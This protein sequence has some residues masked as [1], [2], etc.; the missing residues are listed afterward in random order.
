MS[1][2]HFLCCIYFKTAAYKLLG[3]FINAR[4][5]KNWHFLK[6]FVNFFRAIAKTIFDKLSIGSLKEVKTKI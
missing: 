5:V 4:A 3:R 2:L 1:T 6:F